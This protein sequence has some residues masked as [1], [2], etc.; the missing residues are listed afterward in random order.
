MDLRPVPSRLLQQ[1]YLPLPPGR[2]GVPCQVSDKDAFLKPQGNQ[3]GRKRRRQVW[4]LCSLLLG[5]AASPTEARTELLSVV[6]TAVVIDH[7]P[8][9]PVMDPETGFVCTG[10][11]LLS[12]TPNRCLT[13]ERCSLKIK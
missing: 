8:R 6:H 5:F 4:A 10:V 9:D 7:G 11:L 13:R 12:L 3:A 1:P 2:K